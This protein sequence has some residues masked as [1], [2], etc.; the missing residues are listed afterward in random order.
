ME[1][2]ERKINYFY[3]PQ[4]TIIRK[5]YLYEKYWIVYPY[6]VLQKKMSVL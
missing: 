2:I 6:S 4:K 3:K 1:K 5:G